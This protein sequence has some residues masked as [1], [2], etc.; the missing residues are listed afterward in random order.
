MTVLER[1]AARRLVL[2][3]GKGGTGKSLISAALGRALAA[4]GRNV[5]LVESDPRESLYRLLGVEPSGGAVVQVGPRLRLENVDPAKVVDGLVLEM[6]PI[7]LVARRVLAS[8]VYRHFAAG[9]P[10]IKELCL[11]GHAYNLLERPG[12]AGTLSGARADVVI[13][14]AP[15]TGH[16]VS[17]LDAP[18]LVSEVIE[19]GP[20]GRLVGTLAEYLADRER[21]GT[22]IVT[23][24]EEMP[25]LESLQLIA[26]LR[27]RFH[28]EPDA[29][30]LNALYPPVTR[31]AS[32][33]DDPALALARRRRVAQER[34]AAR[35]RRVWHGPLA[36]IPLFA[37]ESGPALLAAAESALA[38]AL[39]E[40]P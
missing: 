19:R 10:G 35:L 25:V 34:E 11:L 32:R 1:L 14:D 7:A 26:V 17:L 16:A 39:E 24:G 22:V 33:D 23:A 3:T 6:V 36:E 40:A 30:V 21:C 4:L 9:A 31:A 38:L 12:F 27:E 2:V 8:P 20:V 28:T 18:R 15:A 13:L 5:H 29:V 37:A